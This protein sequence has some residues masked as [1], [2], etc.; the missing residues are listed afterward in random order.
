MST[1]II[2]DLSDT[3]LERLRAVAQKKGLSPEQEI[4]ELLE[5]Q[6]ADRALILARI[7]QR[8]KALPTTSAK[9]INAWRDTGRP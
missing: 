4:R 5:T 9:E 1:L 8:W 3:V 7:E 6:Y 2:Q